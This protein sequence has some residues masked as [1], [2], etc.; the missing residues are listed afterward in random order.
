MNANTLAIVFMIL[1][2]IF[3]VDVFTNN[4]LSELLHSVLYS[5]SIP[6]YNMK[7]S[8]EKRLSQTIIVENIYLFGE[9]DG[10]LEV[11]SVDLN[12]IYVRN[13]T[14][15]GVV[16][17]AKNGQLIGFVKKTGRVG[18]VVKW[19]ES[20]FP[21][22]I[23][24]TSVKTVGYYSKY[25][26]DVPDP[27]VESSGNVYLSEYAEYGRLLKAHNLSIGRYEDNVFYPKIPRIS[28]YVILLEEYP[29][30]Y[31]SDTT[32]RGE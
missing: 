24:S 13:L 8:L 27:N 23:E 12:G 32:N 10:G 22:T 11:L 26:I 31:S 19:W 15:K 1:L 28:D 16:L 25:R 21:V 29:T 17:S 2:T 4:F 6:M 7:N 5:I 14:K 18:Y 30:N 20:D 9:K 3:V